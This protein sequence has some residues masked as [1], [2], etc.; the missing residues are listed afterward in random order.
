MTDDDYIVYIIYKQCILQE[1]LRKYIIM[2]IY[3][4]MGGLRGIYGVH[5]YIS[6]VARV[7]DTAQ[8][9]DS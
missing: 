4:L 6:H 7:S 5:M 3:M 1:S 9:T 2:C 8:V